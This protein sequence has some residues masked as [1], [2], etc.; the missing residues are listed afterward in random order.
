GRKTVNKPLFN[1]EIQCAIDLRRGGPA[2]GRACQQVD[3]FIGA[4]RPAGRFENV[5]HGLA[6][7]RQPDARRN[8]APAVP[9]GMVVSVIVRM[10]VMAGVARHADIIA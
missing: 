4:D 9:V 1:K 10:V 6:P 7:R 3:H 8:G 2:S 5:E